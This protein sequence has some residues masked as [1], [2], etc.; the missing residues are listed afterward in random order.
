MAQVLLE[1]TAQLERHQEALVAA[2][3][4]QEQ[5]RGAFTNDGK[6]VKALGVLPQTE[7]LA[8]AA[9]DLAGMLNSGIPA[10]RWWLPWG[11]DVRPLL[12]TRA[13]AGVSRRLC[14][15]LSLP[16]RPR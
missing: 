3:E 2:A 4:K 11:E 10:Q 15:C 5:P 6:G 16:R 8:A 12:L 1:V 7:A 9:H 13:A 14:D